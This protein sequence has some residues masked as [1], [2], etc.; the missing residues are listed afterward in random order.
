LQDELSPSRDGIFWMNTATGEHH[1]IMSLD[2]IANHRPNPTMHG[3]R[4]WFNHLLYNPDDTRFIFLHRWQRPGD[5]DFMTRLFT[6]NPDGSDLFCVAGDEYVS[7]FIWRNPRQILAWAQSPERERRF[8]LFTDR[9]ATVKT[10]GDGILTENGH[11]SY[12]PDAGWLLTDTY[13][14]DEGIQTLILYHLESD[15]RIDIGRFFAPPE[16]YEEIR[17]DL[18]PRWSRDGKKVCIDSAH[19]GS[20]Q[21]YILDLSSVVC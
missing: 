13:P 12:S 9:T 3:A 11:C 14:D 4:H 5:S 19:T 18:H 15:R 16:L 2:Q 7:H 8:F 6:A 1:L 21:M 17:C 20:R 10:I